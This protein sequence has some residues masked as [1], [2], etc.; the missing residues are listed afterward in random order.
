MITMLILIAAYNVARF[1][2]SCGLCGINLK[3]K[4]QGK[5]ITLKVD[6]KQDRVAR[7]LI[8]FIYIYVCV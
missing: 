2:K 7:G 1:P 3:K 4:N 6:T 5:E 8:H